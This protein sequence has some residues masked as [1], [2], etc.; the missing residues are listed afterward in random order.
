MST[1]ENSQTEIEDQFNAVRKDSEISDK[2]SAIE[3]A[4]RDVLMRT[5]IENLESVQKVIKLS[6]NLARQDLISAFFPVSLLVDVFDVK[7]LDSCENLFGFVEENVQVFKEPHFF[8]PCKN[9]LL[10]MCND[11]LRRLSRSQNTVFCGRILLFLANFFPF[12][13]RSGLNV[14]SEFNIE[15]TTMF[16]SSDSNGDEPMRE[17]EV[18]VV[19][20]SKPLKVDKHLYLKF[21]E[22][23][24]FFRCPYKCYDK[25]K[26]KIF[27]VYSK[28]VL[29]TFKSFKLEDVGTQN[30]TTQSQHFFAKFLTNPK[31]LSL[32]LGDSNFR[33]TILV[34]FLILSQYLVSNVKFKGENDK[35]TSQQEEWIKEMESTVYTL[36]NETPP[37]G[38]EFSSS[39]KHILKREELWNN[40]KNEGCKEITR[41]EGYEKPA[42]EVK[43]RKMLGD[44]IWE[45]TKA[46]KY[47]LGNSELSRLWNL[48]PDN[49]LACKGT[50]R[51]FLPPLET[52]LEHK[53]KNDPTYEWRAL[54]LVSR[55]SSHFFALL[56]PPN[57][58]IEKISDYLKFFSQKIQKEKIDLKAENS[59]GMEIAEQPEVLSEEN[60]NAEVMEE[61][62]DENNEHKST[63]ATA[64]QIAE[65]AQSVGD[66]WKKLGAKLGIENDILDYCVEKNDK[67]PCEHMLKVWF[68]EDEDGCLENL[69]YTLEGLEIM[70]AV[71][72]VKKFIDIEEGET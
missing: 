28:D 22:L 57:E 70:D 66:N 29:S 30:G 46:G 37:N 3:H 64:E 36:L 5:A 41:P 38:K 14:V 61:N 26:F 7:T 71:S 4:L 6:M 39:I 52:Y 9:S 48:C 68:D 19:E 58:K 35:L 59:G 34:Q 17:P 54:R 33:R 16:G 21:W 15:N 69:A 23:Q 25:E 42:P 45:A 60:E 49:L 27:S 31:L 44:L 72:I 18:T 67:Q 24:D 55:Q 1:E 65:I 47:D 63:K 56:A 43:K 12:S 10:R 51:N 13:E 20:E 2:K 53:V 32:Q 50:D 40:W 62:E 11:L 8:T